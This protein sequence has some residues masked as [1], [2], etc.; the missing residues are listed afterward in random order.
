MS[1][2]PS[3]TY[4]RLYDHEG[5]LQDEQIQASTSLSFRNNISVNGFVNRDLERFQQ[6]DFRKTGYGFFGV[7]SSPGRV[8]LRRVQLGGTGSSTTRSI[9]SSVGR[10]SAT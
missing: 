7:I 3:V 10:G 9:L 6:V 1:W 4:L 8:D 5:V 2:G